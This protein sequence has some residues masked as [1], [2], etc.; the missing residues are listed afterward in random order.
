MNY[1]VRRSEIA[2]VLAL[3]SLRFPIIKWSVVGDS[4]GVSKQ[5]INLYKNQ[6]KKGGEAK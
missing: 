1:T 4:L 5:H 3:A 2:K 6:I